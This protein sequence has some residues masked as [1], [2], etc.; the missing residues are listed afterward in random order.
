MFHKNT[1]WLKPPVNFLAIRHMQ[2]LRKQ[3]Q[4]PLYS[5]PFEYRTLKSPVFHIFSGFWMLNSGDSGI[6]I[7]LGLENR[8]CSVFRWS[9]VFSFRMVFGFRM[10]SFSLGCFKYYYYFFFDSTSKLWT[11][12]STWIFKYLKFI[13]LFI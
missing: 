3:F 9:N 5:R 11:G 13:Y 1:V 10:V 4:P 7:Q 12:W 2:F 8:T 6:L